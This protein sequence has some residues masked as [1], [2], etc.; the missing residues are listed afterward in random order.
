MPAFFTSKTLSFLRALKRNNDRE[1]FK[2]RKAEFDAHVQGP[3]HALIE[4]LAADMGAFAPDLACSPRESTFRQY[5]DTR[6]SEDKS[7]LKTHVAAVFPARGLSRGEGAGLYFQIDP[8]EVWIG[9]GLYHAPAP[10]LNAVRQHIAAN[11]KHLRAI[12]ESPSF[13]KRLGAVDGD[14]LTRVPRGFEA[15]HPAAEY[16]K[17]KDLIVMKTFPGT[18]AATPRFYPTLV[19]TFR[20]AAPFVRFLNAPILARPR[21]TLD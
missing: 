1:W 21:T 15:D 8:T 2:A 20:D 16:L 7:P 9:G 13:R 10:T 18:F 11:L 5:R 6:F 17:L 19:A 14:R 4:Q 12:V 3:L